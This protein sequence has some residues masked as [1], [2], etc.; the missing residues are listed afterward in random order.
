MTIEEWHSNKFKN[1]WK[2]ETALAIFPLVEQES[3]RSR[4]CSYE[5]TDSS[6]LNILMNK[7]ASGLDACNS[8]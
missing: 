8:A 6:R 5:P 7:A 3:R 1:Y 2:V 4:A